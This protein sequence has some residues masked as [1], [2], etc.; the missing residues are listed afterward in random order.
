[1][2]KIIEVGWFKSL[3][4]GFL[5]YCTRHEGDALF[6][7]KCGALFT[8]EKLEK[9]EQGTQCFWCVKIRAADERKRQEY[10]QRK[11]ERAATS[12]VEKNTRGKHAPSVD[13]KSRVNLKRVSLQDGGTDGDARALPDAPDMPGVSGDTGHT[14]GDES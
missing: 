6:R 10:E 2:P 13:D 5:H 8:P 11:V 7:A 4:D 9:T 14:G 12:R 1:M 3:S